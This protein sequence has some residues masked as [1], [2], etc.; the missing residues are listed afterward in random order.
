[1][2]MYHLNVMATKK[3]C[4]PLELHFPTQ[5]S[6]FDLHILLHNATRVSHLPKTLLIISNQKKWSITINTWKIIH[7]IISTSLKH[8]EK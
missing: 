1:M 8:Y 2:P 7:K 5:A 3:M 6:T 4:F